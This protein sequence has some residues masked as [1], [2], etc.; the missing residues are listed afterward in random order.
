VDYL[1]P[2]QGA[3]LSPD[4]TLVATRLPGTDNEVGL[5]DV[6]SG[7][8]LSN[9]LTEDDNV[10]A[11]APGDRGTISYVLA[12]NGLTPGRELQL[13]TC[14]VRTTLCHIAARIPNMGGTPVLAR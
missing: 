13:R 6:N 12:P 5:Y 8:P 9:G 11:F 1:V 10:L 4:G 3:A 2:G 7:R 14:D